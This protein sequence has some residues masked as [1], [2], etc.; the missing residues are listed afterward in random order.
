MS[1]LAFPKT[2]KPLK[3]ALAGGGIGGLTAALCLARAGHAVT[4]YEQAENFLES[5]AGVQI[6]PNAAWVLHALDLKQSLQR[7]GFLPQATQIRS[8]RSGRVISHTPLG[9]AAHER[10]GAPYY[11]VHRG[12]LLQLLV[13]KAQAQPQIE[14]V[15]GKRISA[16]AQDL[17]LI[18]I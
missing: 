10:Y 3:V 4:V 17:S 12:D 18:H 11:H 15:L 14:L 5:G 16:L 2:Q 8:W 13:A 9:H 7:V 1:E 6:S